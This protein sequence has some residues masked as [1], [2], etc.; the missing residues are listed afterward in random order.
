MSLIQSHEPATRLHEIRRFQVYRL[1]RPRRRPLLAR[2]RRTVFARLNVAISDQPS[3]ISHQVVRWDSAQA[4]TT[5]CDAFATV[6]ITS[7]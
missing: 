5:A 6:A 7:Y 3:A 2:L 4:G 1:E